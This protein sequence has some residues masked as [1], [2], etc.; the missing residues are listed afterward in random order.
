MARFGPSPTSQEGL[1]NLLRLHDHLGWR[2]DDPMPVHAE[3]DW[4]QGLGSVTDWEMHRTFNMGMGMCLAVEA[5]HATAILDWLQDRGTGAQRVGSVTEGARRPT[6]PGSRPL[7][8]VLIRGRV[9]TTGPLVE[10]WTSR[11]SRVASGWKVEPRSDC[12]RRL[13]ATGRCPVDLQSELGLGS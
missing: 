5:V 2:I 12:M 8:V 7:R 10:P 3:F 9:Y 13:A 1:S 11:G 4:L 6:H